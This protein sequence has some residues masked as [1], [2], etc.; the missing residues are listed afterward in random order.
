ML[1]IVINSIP[2]P[3]AKEL[4]YKII[5]NQLAACVNIL[6]NV[7]SIYYWDG[8]IVEDE[9]CLLFIKTTDLQLN[10]LKEFIKRNHPYDVPEIVTINHLDVN[11]KYYNWLKN[12]VE[13]D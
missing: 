11:T 13:K 4:S 8:K 7:K 3:K 1:K 12:Y 9:E 6:N 2:T 10:E 5:E